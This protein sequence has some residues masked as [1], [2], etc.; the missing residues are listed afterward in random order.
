M[1]ETN[2]ASGGAP[3][4][5]RPDRSRYVI[6]ALLVLGGLIAF[7]TNAFITS[8]AI[9]A[10]AK[11]FARSTIPG[12][13]TTDLHP[14]TWNVWLEGP[15][16]IDDVRV[17]DRSGATIDV[18]MGGG[19]TGYTRDGFTAS[20]VA[21]FEIPRGGMMSGARIAV[22]GSAEFPEVAFSVGPADEFGY[23]DIA[24]YGTVVVIA[25]DLLAIALIVIVPIVRARR[26]R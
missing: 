25:I 24:R 17:T 12:T 18:R 7:G 14:G 13:I 11:S 3:T 9:D 10:T 19:G 26:R 5:R 22:N 2:G 4:A 16:T 1:V 23:V 20:K 8:A 6:V 21:S 15:G